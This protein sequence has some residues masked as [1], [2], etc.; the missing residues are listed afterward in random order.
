MRPLLWLR[1]DSR[2]LP[3]HLPSQGQGQ[4]QKQKQRTRQSL[5]TMLET[6]RHHPLPTAIVRSRETRMRSEMWSMAILA[7]LRKK[8]GKTLSCLV[9]RVGVKAFLVGFQ[10]IFHLAELTGLPSRD[11]PATG[12]TVKEVV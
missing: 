3:P 5:G 1:W 10:M 6:E 4:R 2:E 7:R 9:A 11:S 8:L 12:K